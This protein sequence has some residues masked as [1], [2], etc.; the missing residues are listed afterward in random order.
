MF[1]FVG[2]VRFEDQVITHY[3]LSNNL[4][5][6]IFTLDT[7]RIF[8]ETYSV[9]SRTTERY[10]SPIKAFYPNAALLQEFVT[11]KGRVRFEVGLAPSQDAGLVLSSALLRVASAVYRERGRG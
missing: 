2:C 7:G 1:R 4:P 5:I 11:E 3:I 6:S 8:P 9:W 10:N